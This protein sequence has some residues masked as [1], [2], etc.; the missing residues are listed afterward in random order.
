MPQGIPYAVDVWEKCLLFLQQNCET[1]VVSISIYACKIWY[2]LVSQC[3]TP[4]PMLESV[5]R[6]QLQFLKSLL[7]VKQKLQLLA[8]LGELKEYSLSVKIM[9]KIIK[10]WLR[11]P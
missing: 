11:I 4:M 5:D 7:Q 2:P 1:L 8:F 6:S 9:T 3:L 10:Y